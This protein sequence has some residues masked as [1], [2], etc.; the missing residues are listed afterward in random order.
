MGDLTCQCAFEDKV[1]I[2][3][4][5]FTIFSA[6]GGLMV[7]PVCV[8]ILH[9]A[10]LTRIQPR[11]RDGRIS[12]VMLHNLRSQVLHRWYACLHHHV[13]SDG[14]GAVGLRLLLDQLCFAPLFI[15][16][17]MATLRY[18]EGSTRPLA[19]AREHWWDTVIANWK[20]W[21]PAQAV[22]FGVVA[23][24]YQVLF[25]NGVAVC[26]NVYLSW[27]THQLPQH[28]PDSS[29]HC[30]ASASTDKRA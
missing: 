15:P 24:H 16:T 11:D 22:N 6:M 23:P 30:A 26:W 17:F 3:W 5:R 13:P 21:V 1:A 27:A 20:L 14:V 8:R 10:F 25:A 7:G 12:C 29:A 9:A 18:C 19:E 2:D 28:V 4:R